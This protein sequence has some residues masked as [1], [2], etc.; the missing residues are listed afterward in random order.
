SNPKTYPSTDQLFVR[1]YYQNS[2]TNGSTQYPHFQAYSLFGDGRSM[3]DMD[4]RSFETAISAIMLPGVGEWCKVC[5]SSS[6]FCAAY[7]QSSSSG[8]LERGNKGMTLQ[9]AG[10]IGAGVTLGVCAILVPLVM[11]VSGLR[12]HR[13]PGLFERKSSL[14]GFKGNAKLAS[15]AD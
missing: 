4:W 5:Q 13:R 8:G 1:F 9:V 7:T 10:V 14:G 2:S 12:F 11:L 15:D 6:M 3:M